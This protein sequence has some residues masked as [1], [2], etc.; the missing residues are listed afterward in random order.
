M[1][2]LRKEE[3][4]RK[5]KIADL[6]KEIAQVEEK[7]AN[8]PEVEDLVEINRDLSAL[9]AEADGFQQEYETLQQ[10]IHDHAEVTG[11]LKAARAAAQQR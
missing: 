9:R 11:S 10:R 1:E 4:R 7:I 2:A 6:R 3:K 5:T 8:P